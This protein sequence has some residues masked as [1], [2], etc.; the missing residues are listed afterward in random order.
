MEISTKKGITKPDKKGMVVVQ[1]SDDRTGVCIK[2]MKFAISRIAHL[3][4][5]A[6]TTSAYLDECYGNRVMSLALYNHYTSLTKQFENDQQQKI[7]KEAGISDKCLLGVLTLDH[8]DKN[9]KEI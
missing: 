1:S 7:C 5:S 8:S 3:S 4:I 6:A 2:Q 9:F